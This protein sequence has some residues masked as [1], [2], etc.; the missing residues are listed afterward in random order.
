MCTIIS[1]F[2]VLY[3]YAALQIDYVHDK[4]S[5]SESLTDIDIED[6]RIYLWYIIFTWF[7]TN[8]QN[9]CRRYRMST[10]EFQSYLF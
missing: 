2:E 9:I 1:L 3:I 7:E 6:T 10:I 8:Y 4:I 5:V